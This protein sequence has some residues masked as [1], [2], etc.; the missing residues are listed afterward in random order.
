MQKVEELLRKAKY[1]VETLRRQNEI[2]RAK[3]DTMELMA[4]LLHT[5]AAYRSQGE[6]IDIVWEIQKQLNTWEAEAH[7]ASEENKAKP[8][9]GGQ[10]EGE[11]ELDFLERANQ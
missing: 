9:Y 4:T 3:V 10:K 8:V 2:L 6:T 1:E 11:S 7:K 5:Q